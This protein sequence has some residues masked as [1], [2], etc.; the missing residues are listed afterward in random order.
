LPFLPERSFLDFSCFGQPQPEERQVKPM[1]GQKTRMGRERLK[2]GKSLSERWP[3]AEAKAIKL[4]H[5]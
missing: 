2:V 3:L 4:S 5:K 1:K